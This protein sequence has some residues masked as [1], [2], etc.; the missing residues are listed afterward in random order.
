MYI[1]AGLVSVVTGFYAFF[2]KEHKKRV[3][4]ALFWITFGGIF[5]FGPLMN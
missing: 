2:D 3:G 4:T 5:M 1:V